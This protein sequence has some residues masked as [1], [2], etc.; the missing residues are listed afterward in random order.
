MGNNEVMKRRPEVLLD[1]SVFLLIYDGID[2]FEKINEALLAECEF[3]T[4]WNIID[5]L[6]S[7]AT[8]NHGRRGRAARLALNI[9]SKKVKIINTD[10]KGRTDDIIIKFAESKRNIYVATADIELKNRLIQKVKGVLLFRKS[11]KGFE[12]T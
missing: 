9:I 1:T 7:L 8:R 12:L 6:L 10:L 5:E 2:I 4:L 11:K 3:L